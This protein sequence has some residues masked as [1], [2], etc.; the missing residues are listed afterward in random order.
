[1]KTQFHALV[2]SKESKKK[3]KLEYKTQE[4][5]FSD[6]Q[7]GYVCVKTEYATVNYKDY[8]ILNGNPGLV[9]KYP[10]TPG[11]DGSGVVIHSNSHRF[12]ENDCVYSIATPLGVSCNGTFSEYFIANEN[13][14]TKCTSQINKRNAIILGTAGLTACAIGSI[15]FKGSE[16]QRNVLISAPRSR[17]SNILYHILKSK[18]FVI[19]AIFR[20]REYATEGLE[21]KFNDLITEE[22]I[23]NARNFGLRNMRWDFAVDLLGS[24]TT[25]FMLSS[26][27]QNGTLF[28]VGNINSSQSNLSLLPFFLRG[29]RIVGINAESIYSDDRE[30]LLSLAI[31]ADLF[32]KLEKDTEEIEFSDLAEYLVQAD[33]GPQRLIKFDK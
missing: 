11:I 3:Y 1:M 30:D 9:R 27:S 17:V 2:V 32:E 26:L 14:L 28:S 18:N 13:Y 6:L 16:Y 5:D 12:K 15:I 22:E 10:H 31:N 25:S 24:E 33:K 8:L 4:A 29:A 21:A 23:N 7:P 19:D 20:D